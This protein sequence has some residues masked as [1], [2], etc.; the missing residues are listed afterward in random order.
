[1]DPFLTGGLIAAGGS[2]TQGLMNLFGRKAADKRAVRFWK[3]QNAYNHPAQQM[4]RLIE[5]GLNPALVYGQSASGATG[6]AGSIDAPPREQYENPLQ[7]I[8]K[9]QDVKLRQAQH[10]NVEQMITNNQL[11]AAFK[12]QKTA[13]EA[14]KGASSKLAYGIAQELRQTSIDAQKEALESLR[15]QTYGR[16][17][18]NYVKDQTA[19]SAIREAFE[20][21]IL[22]SKQVKGQE[23]LNELRELERDLNA[24]GIQKNDAMIFR[25]LL[26]AYNK[27]VFDDLLNQLNPFKD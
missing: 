19:A 16:Q 14:I 23:L 7:H 24:M 15:Q 17:I 18:D 12:V 27:G 1:M 8:T 3:M 10:D 6:Q 26:R 25:G 21:A 4:E 9:F 2:A 5:A 13:N 11:E 20:R 22:A